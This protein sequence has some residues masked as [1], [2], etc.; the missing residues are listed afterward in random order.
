MSHILVSYNAAYC[1]DMRESL[2]C[3]KTISSVSNQ[4]V[5]NIHYDSHSIYIREIGS[6]H[7]SI[8]C[9]VN[10]FSDDVTLLRCFKQWIQ[11]FTTPLEWV[12]ILKSTRALL[13]ACSLDWSENSRDKTT[14]AFVFATTQS[15]LAEYVLA[16]KLQK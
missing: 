10:I 6:L 9:V 13:G 1:L 5:Q 7:R 14:H 12:N 11:L 16:C 2:E 4:S 3:V 15:R 8:G